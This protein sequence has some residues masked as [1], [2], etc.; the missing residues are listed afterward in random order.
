MTKDLTVVMAVEMRERKWMRDPFGL[1][2]LVA[3]EFD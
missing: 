1:R 2:T 3:E